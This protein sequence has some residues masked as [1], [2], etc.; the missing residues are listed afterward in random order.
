M[1]A[2]W[3]QIRSI[4]AGVQD[5]VIREDAC[6]VAC[7][8]HWAEVLSGYEEAFVPVPAVGVRADLILT[9]S[10]FQQKRGIPLSPKTV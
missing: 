9:P 1:L 7:G 3:S 5:S 8:P 10:Q 2:H 4:W 6:G